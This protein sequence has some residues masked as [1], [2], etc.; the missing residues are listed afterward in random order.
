MGLIKTVEK[1]LAFSR[2]IWINTAQP[3]VVAM[4][5][6]TR[7]DHYNIHKEK[8]AFL[9]Y[10]IDLTAPDL[11]DIINRRLESSFSSVEHDR[12]HVGNSGFS[13]DGET[14]SKIVSSINEHVLDDYAQTLILE[15]LSNND[16]RK[17][18]ILFDRFLRYP[19]L[20]IQRLLSDMFR[21]VKNDDTMNYFGSWD[22]HL[23]TGIIVG[24]RQYYQEMR[25]GPVQNVLYM[26]SVDG[27]FDYLLLYILLSLIDIS[28]ASVRKVT[29]EKVCTR[30]GYDLSDISKG[31]KFLK[32]NELI[33]DI[34]DVFKSDDLQ[35]STTIKG[36][37]YIRDFVRSD[38]YLYNVIVDV[39][40]QH[41]HWSDRSADSFLLR[42]DSILEYLDALIEAEASALANLEANE[43]PL[44]VRGVSAFKLM[45]SVVHDNWSQ[46]L[47]NVRKT[48]NANDVL[49]SLPDIERRMADQKIYIND[50][51]SRLMDLVSDRKGAISRNAD[52]FRGAVTL[53]DGVTA[54]FLDDDNSGQMGNLKLRVTAT[55]KDTLTSIAAHLRYSADELVRQVLCSLSYDAASVVFPL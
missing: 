9:R 32:E 39:P 15:K 28:H 35:L 46:K 12:A 19:K 42:C 44:E 29:L 2:G 53:A 16:V 8:Q 24:G 27:S 38:V 37:A 43:D 33:S 6:T 4:R 49:K 25:E 47:R 21:P 1:L 7:A 52:A 13:I 26:Q 34:K 41:S 30:C 36:R 45:S 14:A 31:L 51:S 5:P 11:K 23:L 20:N 48:S 3:T 18:L 50:L 10:R 40:L 17:A 54:T 55:E 22:E